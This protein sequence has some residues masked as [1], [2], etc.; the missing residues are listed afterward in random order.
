MKKLFFLCLIFTLIFT[1]SQAPMVA[2]CALSR[3]D[4]WFVSNPEITDNPLSDLLDIS[5]SE[6]GSLVTFTNQGLTSDLY[7]ASKDI[8]GKYP[9]YDKSRSNYRPLETIIGHDFD[10]N[11]FISA[12]TSLP[13]GIFEFYGGWGHTNIGQK[14]DEESGTTTLSRALDSTDNYKT[15]Q[16]VGDNR[17]NDTPVP[18]PDDQI[19]Y[20]FYQGKQYDIKITIN[21]AIN[22]SYD[23]HKTANSCKGEPM[24]LQKDKKDSKKNDWLGPL[25]VLILA[26]LLGLLLNRKLYPHIAKKHSSLRKA[27][28]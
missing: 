15:R 19:M 4:P 2:G 23:P 6:N 28:K 8:D 12:G 10:P 1:N 16:I 24:V 13:K 3:G 18:Q 5:F 17:P 20:A 14:N 11:I 9:G 7:I 21:Y 22:N 27:K 25:V 26:L